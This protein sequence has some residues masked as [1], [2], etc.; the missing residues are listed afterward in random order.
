MIAEQSV[1]IATVCSD[2]RTVCGD[3][4]TVCIVIP[5]QS[6]VIAE[7]SVVIA[8]QSVV[9]AEQSVVIAKQSSYASL[10]CISSRKRSP[11]NE[12]RS[13]ATIYTTVQRRMVRPVKT[14]VT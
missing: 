10:I 9:I 4:R 1:V 2:S 6:V 11:I 8:E 12:P 5:E 3:S 14:R 13:L 7:Q